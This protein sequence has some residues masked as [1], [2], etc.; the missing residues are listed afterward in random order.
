MRSFFALVSATGASGFL[1][2]E[3]DPTTEDGPDV[4]AAEDEVG[5]ELDPI[6]EDDEDDADE[7]SDS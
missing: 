2:L 3:T 1:S 5:V 4:A 6:G 7:E